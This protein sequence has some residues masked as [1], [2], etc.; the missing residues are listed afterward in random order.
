M[1]LSAKLNPLSSISRASLLAAAVTFIAYIP[2]LSNGFLNWDDP[3]Y[4]VQ[5]ERIRDLGPEFLIWVFTT[6][7]IANWHPL[8]VISHAID[9][10]AWGLEP[11]GHHLSSVTLHSVNTF[12][13]SVLS[14]RLISSTNFGAGPAIF[15][16]F[17]T[18]L[19]FG[20][21]PLHV[22]SVA[23]ISERK[24][25]LCMLFFLMSI[26]FYLRYANKRNLYDYAVS[27]LF[28]AFS[29]MSK[30]MAISLPFVLLLL[31]VYPLG[32]T[33]KR[34]RV[35]IEKAPFFALSAVSG[36]LTLWAQ[37]N[38]GAV[39][40]LELHPLQTRF[41]VAVSSYGAYL[42]KMIWP[43]GLAP[44]YTYPRA[45]EAVS[46]KYLGSLVV[47]V[48]LTAG[49]VM[50]FKRSKIFCVAWF[51]YLITLFPVIGIVQVGSQAAADRYTY[52]PALSPFLLAG[53]GAGWLYRKEAFRPVTLVVCSLLAF[54][55]MALTVKQVNI[56]KDS[57]TLWTYE[58]RVMGDVFT[59]YNNR[60]MA[61]LE[62]NQIDNALSDLNKAIVLR[63]GKADIY[64]HRGLIHN[65][66][67]DYIKAIEDFDKAISLS[68]S[69]LVYNNRGISNKALGRFDRALEDLHAALDMDPGLAEAY[70]NIGLI[71]SELGEYEAAL[72]AKAKASELGYK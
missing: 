33:E 24:D 41:W 53:I 45:I 7:V 44:L 13:V 47:L 29:L 20:V 6:P 11:F 15:A 49:S 70:Y 18:A 36:L 58:I 9:Y 37:N 54:A 40:T 63:P 34:G 52:I 38:A 57:V 12:L 50:A 43:A 42:Y 23:W 21:H 55:L 62:F 72:E 27:L 65:E 19:L 56:W 66:K 46:L 2:A 31:D 51:F 59:A 71:Y 17:I 4:V 8:T 35:L 39:A 68:P 32:R 22:E 3:S 28:F 67:G 10:A 5:N 14:Y 16:S 61:Y 48:L 69:A 26:L 30:P 64:V 60:A 25:V 1:S